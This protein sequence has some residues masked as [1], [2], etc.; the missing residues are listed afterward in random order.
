M[1]I[2]DDEQILAIDEH[3][4][5]DWYRVTCVTSTH[6]VTGAVIKSK[7]DTVTEA[8][9]AG[10]DPVR[11]LKKNSPF[12]QGP[13]VV[14]LAELTRLEW[15]E[16]QLTLD[17]SYRKAAR[18]R[19]RR[20]RCLLTSP[21][22]RSELIAAIESVIGPCE[23]AVEPTSIWQLGIG[24]MLCS[25]V[26]VLVFG[27]TAWAGLVAGRPFNVDADRFDIGRLFVEFANLV[28]PIGMILIGIVIV[29]GMMLWWNRACRTPPQKSV[30]I[31]VKLPM[32]NR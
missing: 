15:F 20:V 1:G 14:I 12:G 9:A 21:E 27:S 4:G 23:H 2:S 30:L 28:G 8:F 10:D 3:V 16:G 26:T 7:K 19:R 24:P 18:R 31:P 11:V 13:R 17:M 32:R 29:A 22:A 25:I 6:L 5:A